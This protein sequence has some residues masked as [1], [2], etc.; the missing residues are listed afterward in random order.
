[1]TAIA[2]FPES[3]G[4]PSTKFLAVAGSKQSSGKTAGEALDAIT[5]QLDEPVASTLIVVQHACHDPFFTR[6]Q[7]ERLQDL[8]VRWRQARDAGTILSAPEQAELDALV[9]AELE[10]AMRRTRSLLEELGP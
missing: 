9:Q 3:P 1:M 6:A 8:M 7:Q 10:G 4:S 2:I 5:A